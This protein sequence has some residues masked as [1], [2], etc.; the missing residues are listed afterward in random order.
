M[1]GGHGR[2][3]GGRLEPDV[4]RRLRL[5]ERWRRPLLE[6]PSRERACLRATRRVFSRVCA[7]SRSAL[8]LY[9]DAAHHIPGSPSHVV[10]HDRYQRPGHLLQ[11][12]PLLTV[13]PKPVRGTVPVEPVVLDRDPPVRPGEIHPPR[14]STAVDD[15]ILEYRRRQPAVAH[16][17]AG[18]TFHRR[19]GQFGGQRNQLTHI[20]NSPPASRA[21][22]PLCSAVDD[23][24][25]HSGERR[26][27]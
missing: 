6:H 4:V 24:R 22:R 1:R 19:F 10:R 14:P 25:C 17:Q 23:R 2:Q 9:L 27:G 26:R 3:H 11:S 12:C 18:L 16:D 5:V 15:L 7:R 8:K 20:H 13:S 21:A